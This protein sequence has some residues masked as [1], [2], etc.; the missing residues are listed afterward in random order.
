MLAAADLKAFVDQQVAAG[1][2]A[3]ISEYVRALLR[4]EKAAASSLR[5]TVL[6]GYTGERCPD[7]C[8]LTSRS[9]VTGIVG[10][11]PGR[12]LIAKLEPP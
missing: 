10:P 12:H 7:G 6:M 11:P 3:S 4:R 1:S 2:Y 5:D 9:E 8:G